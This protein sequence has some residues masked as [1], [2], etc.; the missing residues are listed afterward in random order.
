M[1]PGAAPRTGPAFDAAVAQNV[2]VHVRAYR[3]ADPGIRVAAHPECPPEVLAEADYVGSTSGM[4]NWV[5]THQP[6][7]VVLITECSM[8]DNVAVENP[9]VEFIR[10]CNLCPHMKRIT[11]PKIRRSLETLTHSVEIEPT[12]VVRAR[13]AVERMLEHSSATPGPAS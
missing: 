11:L 5:Q 6:E 8:S 13:R 10:P 9:D 1:K 4:S 3:D 7:K 12:Q 2:A